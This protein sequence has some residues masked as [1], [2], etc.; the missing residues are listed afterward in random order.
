MHRRALFA[1]AGGTLAALAGCAG[2]G[3]ATGSASASASSSAASP[4]AAGSTSAALTTT[5]GLTYIPNVQFAP[6][7]VAETKGLF[8]GVGATVKLRHHGTSEGLFNAIAAGQEDFVIAGGDEM[9]QARASGSDLVAIAAYYHSYPVAILVKDASPITTLADLK[10]RKLG[11][12][13]RYGESW[14]GALVALKTAGLTE[15]DV[16]IVEIGYTQQAAL[17]TG[18]VDAVVGFVNNDQVQ[19]ELAGTKMRAIAIADGI[20][21]L[22]PIVLATT[23]AYLT[24]HPDVAAKVADAMLA[25]VEQVVA[26]PAGAVTT[27]ASYVPSL[28]QKAAR[29]TLDA[30]VKL[31]TTG[32]GGVS[33]KLDA[34]QWAQMATFLHEAGITDTVVD[35]APAVSNVASR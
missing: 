1:L 11:V 21:P 7:Y 2:T 4:S 10:G 29:A 14:F 20:P 18:K 3:A 6:F 22:V 33:G 31:W 8:A 17:G 34:A 35:T 9:L 25:G 26:D 27:S 32:S 28:K 13:G 19:F 30:T 24:A 12:P 23:R 16:T 15:K 5:I